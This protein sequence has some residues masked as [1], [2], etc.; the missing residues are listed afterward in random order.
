MSFA[1][2]SFHIDHICGHIES[3]GSQ[4]Q[5]V[6]RGIVERDTFHFLHV[7]EHRE[8]IVSSEWNLSKS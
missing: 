8:G 5:N 7:V 2:C 4:S 6:V 1:L 3:F